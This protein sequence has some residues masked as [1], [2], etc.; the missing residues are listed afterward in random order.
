MVREGSDVYVLTGDGVFGGTES[1]QTINVIF[2]PGGP[3]PLVREVGGLPT[4]I[5]RILSWI[6]SVGHLRR[7]KPFSE[8]RVER[9]TSTTNRP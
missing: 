3:R 2:C 4:Y 1:H 7:K 9:F 6:G 5:K 8:S